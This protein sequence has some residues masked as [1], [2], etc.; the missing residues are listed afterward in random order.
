MWKRRFQVIHNPDNVI[1]SRK[2]ARSFPELQIQEI[3]EVK[4]FGKPVAK[5]VYG[6]FS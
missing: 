2:M 1:P 3:N 4:T 6:K 5:Q